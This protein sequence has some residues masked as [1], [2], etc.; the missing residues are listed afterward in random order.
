MRSCG[1]CRW[2]FIAVEGDAPVIQCRR[3]PPTGELPEYEIPGEDNPLVWDEPEQVEPQDEGEYDV[4]IDVDVDVLG[5][6]PHVTETDWCGEWWPTLPTM[7]RRGRA[8]A[9]VAGLAFGAAAALARHRLK[10]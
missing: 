7:G 10:R 2:A 3:L 9:V 8:R 1:S 5:R 4:S 6:W